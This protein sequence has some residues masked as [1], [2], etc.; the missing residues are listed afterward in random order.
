MYL[1]YTSFSGPSFLRLQGRMHIAPHMPDS[2]YSFLWLKGP[3]N[4]DLQAHCRG[5]MEYAL[6]QADFLYFA[7]ILNYFI[8]P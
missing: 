1:P 4:L 3:P 7:P 8:R 2:L 6:E 5:F